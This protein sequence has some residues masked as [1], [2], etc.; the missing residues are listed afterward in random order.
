MSATQS[1]VTH[2]VVRPRQEDGHGPWGGAH[3]PT[4]GGLSDGAFMALPLL[5]RGRQADRPF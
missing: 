3:R 4:F 1:P 2:T 5:E